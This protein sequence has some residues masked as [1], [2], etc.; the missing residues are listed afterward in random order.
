MEKTII[1]TSDL[2]HFK[3]YRITQDIPDI[4][5]RITLIKSYDTFEGHVKYG[6]RVSDAAG[7]FRRGG[8]ESDTAM[9]SGEPH[10]TALEVKKRL[11]KKIAADIDSVIHSEKCEKWCL[12]ASEKINRNI[13]ENLNPDVKARLDKNLN[14]DLVKADQSELLSHFM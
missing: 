9:G 7:R 10:N 2:G 14:A 1:I 8:V 5:P 11:A 6:E 13:I 3:A 4:S 12:A